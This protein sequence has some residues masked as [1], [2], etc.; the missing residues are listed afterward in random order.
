MR[1]LTNKKCIV[2]NGIEIMRFPVDSSGIFNEQNNY[3]LKYRF[4]FDVKSLPKEGKQAQL[5]THT[6]IQ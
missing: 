4:S 2:L 5:V 3:L 1:R 6:R